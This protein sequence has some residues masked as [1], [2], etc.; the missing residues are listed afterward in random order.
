M[1]AKYGIGSNPVTKPGRSNH[2]PKKAL[3][4]DMK[5]TN[6]NNKKLKYNGKIKLVE[7]FNDLVIVGNE[8]NIYWFGSGDKPHWSNNGK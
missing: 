3:A 2:N 8:F 6:F 4:V 7:R 5:I 1:H